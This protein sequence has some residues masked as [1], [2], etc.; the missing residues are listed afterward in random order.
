MPTLVT[1]KKIVYLKARVIAGEGQKE[2]G[3]E[4][5]IIRLLV[6]LQMA[7]VCQVEVL[8]LELSESPPW[9]VGT[10]THGPLLVA[11]AGS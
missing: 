2:R 4:R 11:L 10:Q 9:A 7:A 6:T 8:G 1:L 5:E 3:T